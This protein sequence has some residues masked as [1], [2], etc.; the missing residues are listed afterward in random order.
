M[1]YKAGEPPSPGQRPT[2]SRCEPAS[3][4][5]HPETLTTGVAGTA[6]HRWAAPVDVLGDQAW[7][8]PAG[9]SSCP[10]S[11]LQPPQLSRDGQQALEMPAANPLLPSPPKVSQGWGQGA[12]LRSPWDS[13]L[14][15]VFECL[16]LPPA[17]CAKVKA[18]RY[19][20]LEARIRHTSSTRLGPQPALRRKEKQERQAV[21]SNTT[22]HIPHLGL[23]FNG[24][25]GSG[26]PG[27]GPGSVQYQ[28][29][30]C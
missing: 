17:L 14:P 20:A 25:F 1:V 18:A 23:L 10:W 8:S 24:S 28:P 11:G 27:A 3:P 29:A 30:P 26:R 2:A 15:L 6:W 12:E 16:L 5:S 7:L 21:H 13:W 9:W 4:R 19:P 22:V